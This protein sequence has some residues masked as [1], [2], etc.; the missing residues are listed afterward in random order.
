MMV[1]VFLQIKREAASKRDAS[2]FKEAVFAFETASLWLKKD[3]V[4][5]LRV[6]LRR[7][8]AFSSG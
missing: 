8:P 4:I 2:F 3:F 6:K 1:I 5:F 7:W